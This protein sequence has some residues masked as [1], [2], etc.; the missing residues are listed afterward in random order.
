MT[1]RGPLPE[2]QAA[3]AGAVVA[4]AVCGVAPA[5]AQDELAIVGATVI[6]EAGAP[7]LPDGSVIV[8]DGRVACVGPA[9]HCPVPDGARV[10]DGRG[11]W[12]MPG[13][14]D[15]HVHLTEEAGR[16]EPLYLAFGITSVRD[17]GG[18]ADTLRDLRARIDAGA[19]PGP[20]IWFAGHPLDGDP[21]RWA[22]GSYPLVPVSVRTPDEARAAVRAVRASGADFVKLYMGLD[23]TLLA[24]AVDEAHA[25]GLRAT[26][27]L[28]PWRFGADSA[29]AAGLDGFEHMLPPPGRNPRIWE[30][31][32]AQMQGL[33]DRAVASGASLTTTLVLYER[34]IPAL[35]EAEPTFQAL[36]PALRR[37]STAMLRSL[38]GV[39][40]DYACRTARAFARAG[41]LVLAGTDSYF[42]S[43]YPGDLHRELEL[44][45][46]C[47][48]T[49]A[50]ALAAGT[51][52]S[53]RWLGVH[54]VG[55]LAPGQV[56]DMILLNADPLAD[57]RA[58]RAIQLVIARGRVYTPA[59]LLA[60]ARE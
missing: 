3:L 12:L 56:A 49:P 35:P 25:Q 5:A 28:M 47:G 18:Y 60:A 32:S 2:M 6:T 15:A 22:G 34:W 52:N 55:S 45:V 9:E 27:D 59:E 58:T 51:R 1:F 48:L 16:F 10:I 21:P 23:A 17:M 14:F 50:Q 53:A 24:A 42:T 13:L 7:P 46:N 31:D 8:R 40:L 11:R 39:E 41:G 20:R 54:E 30:A 37:R 43:V 44:L 57:I 29:L 33:V 4:L 26:A 19:E 36:P 38:F